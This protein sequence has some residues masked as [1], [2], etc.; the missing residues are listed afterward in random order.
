M[1]NQ[2]PQQPMGQI[3]EDALSADAFFVSTSSGDANGTT[4]AVPQHGGVSPAVS[5]TAPIQAVLQARSASSDPL[6]AI[7]RISTP[8]RHF[9]VP[10]VGTTAVP[11]VD[12]RQS[13]QDRTAAVTRSPALS[14]AAQVSQQ[15][16]YQS[17][18][19]PYSSGRESLH[20][21]TQGPPA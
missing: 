11:P 15:P 1:A 14:A 4:G 10:V 18:P 9:N 3:D 16:A 20:H 6:G 17:D 2:L 12:T 7:A 8:L 21:I 13:S 5:G 19:T